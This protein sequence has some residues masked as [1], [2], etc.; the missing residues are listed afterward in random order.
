MTIQALA[1]RLGA[2]AFEQVSEMTWTRALEQ[3]VLVDLT[4]IA[5]AYASKLEARLA[6][7]VGTA[8]KHFDLIAPGDRVM[9]GCRA[10]RIAGR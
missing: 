9:V 6:R 5:M 8:I 3:L 1:E 4:R 2:N 7:K 10:G